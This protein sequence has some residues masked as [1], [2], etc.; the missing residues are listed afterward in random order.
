MPEERPTGPQVLI[1]GAGPT[2]L[3]L[4][5]E[6]ARR[7]VP[8]RIVDRS[9]E[10]SRFSKALGVQPRTLELLEK[11]GVSE[12]M[13]ARGRKI[14][15]ANLFAGSQRIGRVE[16]ELDSPYSFLLTFPQSDTEQLLIEE[17]ARLGIMVERPLELTGIDAKPDGVTAELRHVDAEGPVETVQL[18]WLVG[19]D[20]AHSR[21][22]ELLG[23]RFEGTRYEESFCLADVTLDADLPQDEIFVFLSPDGPL[24]VFPM[25]GE[26]QFRLVAEESSPSNEAVTL[27]DFQRWMRERAHWADG[28]TVTIR[29]AV[30]LSRFRVSRR[31]V[32]SYRQG[33]I[34]LAG[35]AA[36]IHSPVG[37]QGMNIGIQDAFNLAWK[38]ALVV[39]G[40]ARESL[41]DS[42]QQE[43]LPVARAV[44]Q[45]TD[46]ATRVAT[47]EQ[48]LLRQLRDWAADAL[49]DFRIVRKQLTQA[50]AD[51]TFNYRK[52]SIVSEDYPPALNQLAAALGGQKVSMSEWLEFSTAPAAGDRAPDVVIRQ[53]ESSRPMRLFDL[54]REPRHILLLFA[55]RSQSAQDG[56][57]L[58][59][60]S[61]D[62]ND[63]FAG[64]IRTYLIVP[65][66]GSPVAAPPG[67]TLVMD[68]E[69]KLHRRYGAARECIYLIRPDGYIAYRAQPPDETKLNAYLSRIFT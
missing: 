67:T 17:L 4:A 55:G 15:A 33:R 50:L 43:R 69:H 28:K 29:E 59:R 61:Q 60:I 10:P 27:G 57:H 51:L 24:A 8:C 54:L 12:P 5:V 7:S 58:T 1:V 31:M 22:R 11:L 21:V 45:A 63:R 26:D 52:S 68:T 48:P 64:E 14:R 53:D 34:F 46:W 39:R 47:L 62:M 42:Y 36:H 20:G 40:R 41:L 19:C 3:S 23:F 30:W 65:G 32:S 9:A 56:Q 66:G 18:S 49:L 16:F 37:G 6:L 13:C 25:P 38:L 2:G 44:L 35:D